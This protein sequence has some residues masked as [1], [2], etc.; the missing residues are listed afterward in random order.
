[1]G[2]LQIL[3]ESYPRVEDFDA[4]MDHW[5]LQGMPGKNQK[6][7]ESRRNCRKALRALKPTPCEGTTRI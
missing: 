7:H 5:I 6:L 3:L 2:E 4:V 1:M